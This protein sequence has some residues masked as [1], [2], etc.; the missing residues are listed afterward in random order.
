MTVRH[1]VLK[2]LAAAVGPMTSAGIYENSD[3]ASDQAAVSQILSGLKSEKLVDHAGKTEPAEGERVMILWD[4][5]KAGRDE[6]QQLTLAAG[7]PGA[8]RRS[9]GRK[10]KRRAKGAH[11]KKGKKHG[12]RKPPKVQRRAATSRPART[13][14]ARWALTADGAFV[15]L[16]TPLEIPAHQARALVEFIRKLDKAEA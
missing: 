10:P 7:D 14:P 2:I 4:I 11:K 3:E 16:G 6:L 13:P 5:T 12:G 1:E 8:S 9:A 15:L